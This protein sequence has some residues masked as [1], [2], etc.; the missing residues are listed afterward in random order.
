MT[1]LVGAQACDVY[2]DPAARS[3]FVEE[4]RRER[5]VDAFTASS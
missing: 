1:R 4:L 2:F 5:R 3:A